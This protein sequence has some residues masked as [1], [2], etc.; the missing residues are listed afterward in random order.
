MED[1]RIDIPLPD[2]SAF[3]RKVMPNG[4]AR[5][6]MQFQEGPATCVTTGPDWLP[7][8]NPLPWQEA[9]FHHGLLETYVL[10]CGWVY[11]LWIDPNVKTRCMDEPGQTITFEPGV[12][13]IVL[14]GPN[15]VILSSTYGDTFPNPDRGY[16]DWWPVKKSFSKQ[17]KAEIAIAEGI[18]R[19]K[20]G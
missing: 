10:V 17:A 6:R 3:T 1:F 7:G 14:P 18:V 11:L 16:K 19:T 20:F 5:T 12:P 8:N 9:H 13:H 15:S 4:E 2:G